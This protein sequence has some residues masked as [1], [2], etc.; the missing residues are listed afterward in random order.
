MDVRTAV[1]ATAV[2]SVLFAAL[3]MS[4]PSAVLAQM[5]TL[6]KTWE[7]RVEKPNKERLPND[8]P[9]WLAEHPQA[10][11]P[12]WT[13][14]LLNADERQ[15]IVVKSDRM[16]VYSTRDG[17]LQWEE[18]RAKLFSPFA[19]V[20]PNLTQRPANTHAVPVP[21][22]DAVLDIYFGEKGERIALIDLKAREVRW[23]NTELQWSLERYA[24]LTRYLKG[25]S[26][27]RGQ[28]TA[29]NVLANFLMPERVIGNLIRQ[30]PELNGLLVK[31]VTGLTMLDL[32]T[33]QVRWENSTF[34]GGIAFA[35]FDPETKDLILVNRDDDIFSLPGI[36]LRKQVLRISAETGTVR[37]EGTYRTAVHD[38]LDG[39]GE[40]ESRSTDV[41]IAGNTLLLN[42]LDLEAFNLNTGAPMWRIETVLPAFLRALDPKSSANNLFAFPKIDAGVIYRPTMAN[43]G[44][45]GFDVLLEA[46][47]LETGKVRWA[48]EKLT[49]GQWITSLVV[50]PDDIIVSFSGAEGL[51]SIDR[52][53]GKVRWRT[54]LPLRGMQEHLIE[55]GGTV[56]V[57]FGNG[58]V[59]VDAQTGAKRYE[60]SAKELKIAGTGILSAGSGLYS[61]SLVAD[62][63]ALIPGSIGL[64]MIEIASGKILAQVAYEPGRRTDAFQYRVSRRSDGLALLTPTAPVGSVVLAQPMARQVTG[65][66]PTSATR[67]RLVLTKDGRTAFTLDDGR[68]QRFEIG[69]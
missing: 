11:D 50:R 69:Q 51:V 60:I 26:T 56:L 16:R 13:E 5:P 12:K 40:F 2:P 17:T 19:A 37:W 46:I 63:V 4:V 67:T 30:I 64:T 41:R 52:T 47:D 24:F 21:H 22:L 62:G 28:A 43:I 10:D 27:T 58:V 8:D 66:L 3:A 32:A 7:T 20:L 15:L 31:T 35:H 9:E 23:V 49:R 54:T 57:R 1:R 33:G 68:L 55:S 25:Q 42:F 59:G 61:S 6:P 18:T 65:L 44:L 36:Q 45:T 38:K 39:V 48:T 14:L 53:S 29:S 34:K